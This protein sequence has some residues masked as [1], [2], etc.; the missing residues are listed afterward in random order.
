MS[1]WKKV[2][3]CWTKPVPTLEEEHDARKMAKGAQK[4]YEEA[5]K[6]LGPKQ[7]MMPRSGA[8]CKKN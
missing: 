6:T 7:V 1:I 8:L 2:Q 3:Q 4:D 5:T